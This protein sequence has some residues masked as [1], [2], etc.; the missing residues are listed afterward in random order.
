LEGT[1]NQ[2]YIDYMHMLFYEAYENI[3]SISES[4]R[5]HLAQNEE[6]QSEW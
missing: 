4:I 3:K 6:E 5:S 2:D 1:V